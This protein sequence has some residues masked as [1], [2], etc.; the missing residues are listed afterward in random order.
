MARVLIIILIVFCTNTAGQGGIFDRSYPKTDFIST[1]QTRAP[2]VPKRLDFAGENVP[3][4][5]FD[6]RESLERELIVNVFWQS[7]T[8]M[9]IKL[10][11]RYFPV[12]EPILREQNVPDDFKYLCVAESGLQHVVSPA[13]AAGFWQIIPATGKEL[14]LEINEEVDERYHIEISTLAACAFLKKSYEL[15]GTWSMAAAAYNM[16]TTALTQQV[17]V[18]KTSSYYNLRLNH[19][20][21]RYVFRMLALKLILSHPEQYG[22]LVKKEELYQPFRYKQVRVDTAITSLADFAVQHGT[23]YK[24][25]KLLNTW[26]REPFLTNKKRKTYYIKILEEGFRDNADK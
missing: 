3:L 23:N 19:E 11:N 6:I 14:G 13:K 21:S 9:L 8:L 22:F 17:L 10:A 25:L 4:Q 15:Y 18:Q 20:T 12:I 26:L 1:S 5:N 16:G 24:M 7:Q 2:E